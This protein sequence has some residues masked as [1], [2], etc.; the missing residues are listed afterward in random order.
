MHKQRHIGIVLTYLNFV[1]KTIIELF[2]IPTILTTLGQNEYGVYQLAASMIS[3]LSLLNMGL[4]G[5]YLKF[6]SEAKNDKGNKEGKLNFTYLILFALFSIVAFVLGDF[7]SRKSE[8]IIGSKLSKEELGLSSILMRF[9]AL[10]L[11]ISFISSVFSSIIYAHECFIFERCINLLSTILNPILMFAAL[12]CGYRSIGLVVATTL[13]TIIKFI[14][15]LIYCLKIIKAPFILGKLNIHFVREIFVFSF[16]IFLNSVIDQVNWNVDKILLGRYIGAASVAVYSIASEINS[17]YILIADVVATMY[18]PEVN[19]LLSNGKYPLDEINSLFI[20]VGKMQSIIVYGILPAFIILG[21]QFIGLWVGNDYNEAYYI[22]LL[23]MIPASISLCETLGIDIQR[24]MNLH[25]FRA[26]VYLGISIIN[27]FISLFL[28][29]MY[30]GI[31][32]ASGTA[33]ALI[34]GNV[35]I[36]NIFYSKKMGLQIQQFWYSI[37]KISFPMLISSL[38]L[39]GTKKIFTCESWADF[40]LLCIFY[41]VSYIVSIFV[42]FLSKEERKLIFRLLKS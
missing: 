5:A 28:I 24:A 1:I 26:L 36:M 17:V 32:A 3:Y 25:K 35:I 16:F 33:L 8:L 38:I 27:I 34:V 30:G 12:I 23:L 37:R 13:V 29:Q 9:L 2:F 22:S 7:I 41:F 6:Y 20:R 31:G 42:F 4:G 11:A 18:A 39:F 21:K 10:N 15:C 14:V 19:R 40:L